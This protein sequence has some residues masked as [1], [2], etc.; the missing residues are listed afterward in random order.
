MKLRELKIKCFR[1]LQN[2]EI[3]FDD[4]LITV[5]I[6]KNG[7]AKSN[8]IEFIA[9]IF[10]ELELEHEPEFAYFLRYECNKHEVEI[11][12]RFSDAEKAMVK[13]G[14]STMSYRRF[15]REAKT[16][17]AYLPTN[18]FIYYSGLS[19]R[20]EDTCKRVKEKYKKEL[21]EGEEPRLRRLFL[22]DGSHSSLILFA[23]LAD[24][25]EQSKAFLKDKL[26]IVGLDS[27]TLKLTRPA[28]L[29]ESEQA[30]GLRLAFWKP[31]GRVLEALQTFQSRSIPLRHFEPSPIQAP[32]RGSRRSE[33]FNQSW[34]QTI[35]FH[36][37]S[38][39]PLEGLFSER[40]FSRPKDLFQR[41][42]DLRLL[43]YGLEINF[44]LKLDGARE[45][46]PLTH[47]SE[48]EQQLL[49]VTG[50]LRFTKDNDTL[51]LLDEPDTH[52]NPQ[53]SYEYRS[54][55]KRAMDIPE[56]AADES[57][58]QIIIATHDPVL[59]AGLRKENVRL[60]ERKEIRRMKGAEAPD[61]TERVITA[62]TPD[63]NPQGMGIARILTSPM[64]GLHSILDEETL[65]KLTRKREL[66]FGSERKDIEELKRLTEELSEVDMT[67]IIEDP[68]YTY[69]VQEI[70]RHPDYLDLKD[71]F[72]FDS[73]DYDKMYQIV[74]SVRDKMLKQA[75]EVE[76]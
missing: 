4:L 53:W 17:L 14:D 9:H 68:L 71:K 39:F 45:A 29:T 32:Q 37:N 22:T 75:E 43:G 33:R 34:P 35:Y 26:G 2:F 70:V 12:A 10:A 49:T 62:T 25:S 74:H 20:L 66:A 40:L 46:I 23:F 7:A 54:M 21:K 41:L 76:V 63:E 72:F 6:G 15:V 65:K 60:M 61:E 42:D 18:I 19:N 36:F 24:T 31:G 59:I 67:T 5:L 47:L 28:W 56:E 55:L 13:V 30:S 1:N 8:L 57:N 73:S 58:S 27:V 50:L 38:M 44:K 48:G 69:F 11:D 52:L 64:F 3:R 51:F 16:Y